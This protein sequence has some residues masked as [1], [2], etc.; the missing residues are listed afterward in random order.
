ML[1]SLLRK[2]ESSGFCS[3]HKR[4]WIPAFAGMTPNIQLWVS[5]AVNG[6]ELNQKRLK[7]SASV[8]E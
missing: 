5:Y 7:G 2:Q 3:N 8:N 1:S 4:H 6:E